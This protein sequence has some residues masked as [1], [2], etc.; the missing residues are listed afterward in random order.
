MKYAKRI[1]IEQAADSAAIRSSLSPMVQ[2]AL[3]E[4]G[5]L[6]QCARTPSRMAQ[7]IDDFMFA[8]TAADI[9]VVCSLPTEFYAH[10]ATK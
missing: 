3:S 10:G 7:I 9:R 1:Q 8:A 4:V 5:K 2:A 6:H